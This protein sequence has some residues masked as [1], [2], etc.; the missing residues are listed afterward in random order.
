MTPLLSRNY[1]FNLVNILAKLI[2]N[3]PREYPRRLYYLYQLCVAIDD[4]PVKLELTFDVGRCL[5]GY[6]DATF[7]SSAYFANHAIDN[8]TLFLEH[9]K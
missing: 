4:H 5:L 3:T 9:R 2:T 7:L 6:G 8:I 1:R